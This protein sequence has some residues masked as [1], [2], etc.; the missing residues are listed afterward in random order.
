M[1]SKQVPQ[2]DRVRGDEGARIR[3]YPRAHRLEGTPHV[4]LKSQRGQLVRGI[5]SRESFRAL[6]PKRT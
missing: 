6:G 4:V 3:A 5:P 1:G 2:I